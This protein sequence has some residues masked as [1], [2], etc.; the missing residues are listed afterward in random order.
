MIQAC[1]FVGT[2]GYPYY[3]YTDISDA[4]NTFWASVNAVRDTVNSIAPGIWV[5]ITETGWPVTGDAYGS[6]QP[7][8]QNL[9]TYWSEVACAAFQQAHTFWYDLRDYTANPSFGVLDANYNPI[10]NLAC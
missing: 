7:S 3:Q 8:Q 10:I 9:Q 5:W 4:S 1:D 6:A 2:D